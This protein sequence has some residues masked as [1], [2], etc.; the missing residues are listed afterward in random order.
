MTE[1]VVPEILCDPPPVTVYELIVPP[2]AAHVTVAV[3]ESTAE[4]ETLVGAFGTVYVAATVVVPPLPL[5]LIEVI[6]NDPDVGYCVLPPRPVTVTGDVVFVA[7]VIPVPET[8]YDDA[9]FATVNDIVIEL[10]FLLC[11]VALVTAGDNV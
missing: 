7:V 5:E 3:L 10:V 11:T 9:P 1:S 4:T 8:E 6:V 2:G